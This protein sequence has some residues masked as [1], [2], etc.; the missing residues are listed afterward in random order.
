MQYSTRLRSQPLGQDSQRLFVGWRQ[1]LDALD[2]AALVERPSALGAHPEPRG[3]RY[4]RRWP[5]LRGAPS[6]PA[7]CPRRADPPGQLCRRS[8]ASGRAAP[9]D[10]TH[11]CRRRRARCHQGRRR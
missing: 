11:G 6:A 4:Q 10:R 2:A 7:R 3:A 8:M 9:P 1:L 5:T